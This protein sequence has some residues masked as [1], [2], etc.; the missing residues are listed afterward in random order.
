MI[1]EWFFSFSFKVSSSCQLREPFVSS[2]ASGFSS[3]NISIRISARLLCDSGYCQKPYTKNSLQQAKHNYSK[4]EYDVYRARHTRLTTSIN[5]KPGRTYK[6]TLLSLLQFST[7]RT[8]LN[9]GQVCPLSMSK[10]LF[11]MDCLLPPCR[12]AGSH[13]VTI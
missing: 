4:F 7:F 5:V 9:V 11:G 3:I 12:T 6:M 1:T 8:D 10:H 2:V 13:T